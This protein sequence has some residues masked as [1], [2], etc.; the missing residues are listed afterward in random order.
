MVSS[1]KTESHWGK[2]LALRVKKLL[3]VP[4]TQ[5]SVNSL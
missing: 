3:Q 1:K 2:D 4:N 5:V